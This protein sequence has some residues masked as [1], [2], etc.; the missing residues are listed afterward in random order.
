[1]IVGIIINCCLSVSLLCVIAFLYR[2][3][4]IFFKMVEDNYH[5]IHEK[6]EKSSHDIQTL[7][8]EILIMKGD[9]KKQKETVLTC[10][11]Q[12]EG[13][14]INLVDEMTLDNKKNVDKLCENY[15]HLICQNVE[16]MKLYQDKLEFCQDKIKDVTVI[17]KSVQNNMKIIEELFRVQLIN[18]LV[19]DAE[20]A[21]LLY[22]NREK[23]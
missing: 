11:S 8:E 2:K 19:D 16:N 21:L 1:M 5:I 15:D 18:S 23:E 17:S 13:K 6:F 10:I 4:N 7:N 12:T 9:L 14:L 3:V 22:R 20:K